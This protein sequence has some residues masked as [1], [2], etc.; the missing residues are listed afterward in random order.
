MKM[1][2][3]LMVFAACAMVAAF[4]A[5]ADDATPSPRF[6]G[7]T[8]GDRVDAAVC[9]RAGSILNVGGEAEYERKR[10]KLTAKYKAEFAAYECGREKG[11]KEFTIEY[12]DKHKCAE[13][14]LAYILTSYPASRAYGIYAGR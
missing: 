3:K 7:F 6:Q 5:V 1:K 14:V 13:V 4:A 9:R 11:T 12:D 2:L 10:Q 8:L